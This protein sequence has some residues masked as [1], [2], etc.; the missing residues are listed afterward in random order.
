MFETNPRRAWQSNE[1]PGRFYSSTN[2]KR[3]HI[4]LAAGINGVFAFR[5][6]LGKVYQEIIVSFLLS[7]WRELRIRQALTDIH[8]VL[9]NATIHKTDLMKRLSA[10]TGMKFLFTSCHSPFMNPV[11]ECFRFI[12]SK[13]RNRHHIN[14]FIHKLF[15][16]HRGNQSNRSDR[17]VTHESF[18]SQHHQVSRTNNFSI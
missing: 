17:S 4:L 15:N 10:G 1:K 3:Y 11:E 2:Y 14:E 6:V 5:V 12:K 8:V 16:S 18:H 7:C 9:D 13:Y